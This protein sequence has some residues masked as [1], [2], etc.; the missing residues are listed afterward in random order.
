MRTNNSTSKEREGREED[1]LS[2]LETHGDEAWTHMRC[3][4]GKKKKAGPVVLPGWVV[5]H[6]LHHL[7]IR[8]FL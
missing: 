6:T 4:S 1:E 7:F 8:F 2:E 5:A 3:P